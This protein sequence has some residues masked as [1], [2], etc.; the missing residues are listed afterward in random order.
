MVKMEEHGTEKTTHEVEVEV[1][2]P[3]ELYEEACKYRHGDATSKLFDIAAS[4]VNTVRLL[5]DEVRKAE[6]AA[7]QN[8]HQ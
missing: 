6:L 2:D 1:E 5:C 7:Q 3:S 8:A 4:L